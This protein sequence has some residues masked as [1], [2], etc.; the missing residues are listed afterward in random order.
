VKTT[1]VIQPKAERSTST[2]PLG[3]PRRYCPA[4][5]RECVCPP[6]ERCSDYGAAPGRARTEV[7]S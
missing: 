3:N 1:I 6:G 4:T 7:G 5:G 2:D